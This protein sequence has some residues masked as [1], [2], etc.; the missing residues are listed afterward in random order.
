MLCIMQLLYSCGV[1]CVLKFS[2]YDL[3][4]HINSKYLYLLQFSSVAQS[5]PTLCDSMNCSTPCLPVHHQLPEFT[6]AHVH[7]AS[8]AIQPSHPLLSLSPPALSLSQCQGL[9]QWV[10]WSHQMA[11]VLS[12]SVSISPSNEYSRLISLS[13]DWFDLLVVQG[14]LKNTVWKYQFLSTQPSLWSNS[15]IHTWL[16]EKLLLFGPLLVR[17]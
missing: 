16:L 3:Q 2:R 6:Q 12:F 15:H 5:C 4:D 8:D 9:F 11:K 14:T 17:W 7:W 13:I 1:N 10:C